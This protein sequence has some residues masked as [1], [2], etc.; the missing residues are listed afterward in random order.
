MKKNYIIIAIAIGIL[1]ANVVDG[2]ERGILM[3]TASDG[4]Y[5]QDTCPIGPAGTYLMSDPSAPCG[6]SW[7]PI[8]IPD[9]PFKVV[10]TPAIPKSATTSVAIPGSTNVILKDGYSIATSGPNNILNLAK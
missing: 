6:V 8:V 4:G 9:S 2:F 10:V 5:Y 3:N 1:S 7:Q